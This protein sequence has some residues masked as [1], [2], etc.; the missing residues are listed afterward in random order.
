MYQMIRRR[1]W[2]D[3]VCP[4]LKYSGSYIKRMIYAYEFEDKSV[5]VGLTCDLKRRHQEHITT[6]DDII[7]KK[8]TENKLKYNLVEKT[9]YIDYLEASKKEGE[10][11]NE[12]VENGWIPLNVS[13]TGGLG[14]TITVKQKKIPIKRI[15]N[16]EVLNFWNEQYWA[17]DRC[18]N[19]AIKYK[20]KKEFSEKCSGAYC[21]ALKLGII[22]DICSHMESLHE[23]WTK[24]MATEEIKKYK[25]KKDFKKYSPKCHRKCSRM[26]WLKEL[27][28]DLI[29]MNEVNTIHT[30]E[31]TKEI[32]SQYHTFEEMRKSSDIFVRG[33]LNWINRKKLKE[34]FR[35]Y[36]KN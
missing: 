18:K 16:G 34:E 31:N 1:K 5:Y 3:E 11:L 26:G 35:Q 8:I 36:L 9:D 20:T 33:A 17:Y 19:E 28:K 23:V 4:H 25:T 32:V 29:D 2:F 27:T 12:Y 24:E 21:G 10:F 15:V 14:G 6:N 7:Y 13:K 30:H 22:D